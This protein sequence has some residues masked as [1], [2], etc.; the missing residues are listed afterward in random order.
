MRILTIVTPFVAYPITFKIC[1][2]L[3]ATKGGGKRKTPNMV[4]RTA[5]GEYVATPAP[6]Y[7]DDEHDELAPAEVPK[8][9]TA[10]TPESDD[11]D[12]VR[13]IDR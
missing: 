4:S 6:A 12:G 1:H 5:E 11:D 8:F 9:I 7:V 13:T 10:S 3:Q 2:E